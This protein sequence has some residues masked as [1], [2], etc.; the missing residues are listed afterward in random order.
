MI[1]QKCSRELNGSKL[2]EAEEFRESR[3]RGN[4]KGENERRERKKREKERD[5]N[6]EDETR[7]SFT[8]TTS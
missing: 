6:E 2:R 8:K 4:K 3:L 1:G 7:I 5:E